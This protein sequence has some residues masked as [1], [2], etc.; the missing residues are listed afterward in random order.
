[1]TGIL[2]YDDSS[3]DEETDQLIANIEDRRIA[4]TPAGPQRELA[5]HRVMVRRMEADGG[6]TPVGALGRQAGWALLGSIIGSVIPG[7]GTGLGGSFGWLAGGIHARTAQTG[8]RSEYQHHKF[9][10]QFMEIESGERHTFELSRITGEQFDRLIGLLAQHAVGELNLTS[11]REFRRWLWNGDFSEQRMRAL[12]DGIRTDNLR[13]LGLNDC[14]LTPRVATSVSALIDRAEQ[15]D[16]LELGKNKLGAGAH[17]ILMSALNRNTLRYLGMAGCGLTLTDLAPATGAAIP[18]LM[19]GDTA[20]ARPTNLSWNLSDNPLTGAAT[21]VTRISQ[22]MGRLMHQRIFS[23]DLS[24]CD[25]IANTAFS[26]P[27]LLPP[28]NTMLLTHSGLSTRQLAGAIQAWSQAAGQLRRLD[29]SA[30]KALTLGVLAELGNLIGL[31]PALEELNLAKSS[32]KIGGIGDSKAGLRVFGAA[33]ALSNSLQSVHL[34]SVFK[35]R[36]LQALNDGLLEPSR[37]VSFHQH[38]GY[39]RV[40]R[41]GDQAVTVFAD[42]WGQTAAYRE[43]DTE[44]S[45]SVM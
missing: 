42:K 25:G 3:S 28:S 30:C 8:F 22:T 10:L 4:E 7:L 12:T 37:A 1:M 6:V 2:T 15:L 27:R 40:A 24:H 44:F 16:H 29:L 33:I 11:V 17:N 32:T 43:R 18:M 23:A 13:T 26:M 31:S 35:A 14:N 41:D 38:A 19:L 20:P 45:C 21:E 39:V 36:E 34:E 9:E 5:T